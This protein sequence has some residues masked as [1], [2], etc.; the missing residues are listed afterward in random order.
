MKGSQYHA[1]SAATPTP[2][3]RM[4][5]TT[6]Y[7]TVPETN[8]AMIL[9]MPNVRGH[10]RATAMMTKGVMLHARPSGPRG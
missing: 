1:E 8:V 6:T 7:P 5:S 2:S 3:L 4:I 10:R 9:M